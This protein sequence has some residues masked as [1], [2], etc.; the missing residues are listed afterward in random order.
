LE[1]VG[2][3][4]RAKAQLKNWDRHERIPD[5]QDLHAAR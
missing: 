1:L 5:D 4:Q 2:A 3:L